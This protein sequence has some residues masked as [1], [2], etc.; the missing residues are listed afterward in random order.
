MKEIDRRTFLKAA[1]TVTT[2]VAIG[3]F[4]FPVGVKVNEAVGEITG[5]PTGNAYLRQKVEEACKNNANSQDC[6]QHY[7]FSTADKVNSIVLTPPLEEL[8]FRGFPAGLV[9]SLEHRE[10]PV[11]DVFTGTGGLG[12]TRREF[13][14]GVTSSALFGVV[15]NV[16]DKGIDTKTIPASQ[17]IG[18]MVYWYIQR[19]LGI[20]ANT[21]AHASNNFRAFIR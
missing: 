3:E 20:A 21:L 17:T 19:K 9:S 13:I 15:H 7:E 2:G 18:G 1:V 4:K 8:A 6:A 12:M 16:T 10:D 11:A 14:I 5:H